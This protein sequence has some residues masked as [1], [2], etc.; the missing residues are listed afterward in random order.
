MDVMCFLSFFTGSNI[1][2]CKQVFEG[3]VIDT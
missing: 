3:I 1:L 2:T